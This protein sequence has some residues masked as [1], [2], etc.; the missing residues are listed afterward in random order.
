VSEFV[1]ITGLA[2]AGRSTAAN[3]FEDMGWFVIDNL[4]PVLIAQMAELVQRP[5]S[6]T[7]RVVFAVGTSEYFDE[8]ESAI[9]ELRSRADKLRIVF[10]DASDDVIVRRFEGTRRRHVFQEKGIAEAVQE[11]RELLRSVKGMADIVVDTSDLNVHQLRERITELFSHDSPTAAM[12]TAVTSF[13]YKHGLPV[14]VDIV[15]DCRFLPNPHWEENLRPLTGLDAPVRNFVMEQ[16]ETA[17]FLERLDNLLD[18]LMPAY[19]KEGKSY[20]T[21]AVGCTGG[22]HRSVAL[23]EEIA[24][25][26]REHGFD[27]AVSH[28]DITK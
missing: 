26:L 12:R 2:G 14:D 1:I 10:L 6:E 9:E 25:R 7:S 18:L 27:P 4:P 3:V 5:G 17:E 11:E 15:L 21:V 13:G 20:L 24:K 28:R 16:P 23:A 22:R 8:L 19:V